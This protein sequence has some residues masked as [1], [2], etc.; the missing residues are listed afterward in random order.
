MSPVA[1]VVISDLEFGGAQRQVVELANNMPQERFDVH[2]VALHD[3][4]PLADQL[5][6]RDRRC[7][8]VQRRSKY[9]FTVVPR[10]AALMR[11]LR[12]EIVHGYLFDAEIASRLAGRLIGIPVIGSERNTG[13]TMKRSN[14]LAYR[15]TRW[16]HNF[17]IANSN[18]GADFNSK[19]LGQSRSTYRVVHNGVDAERFCPGDGSKIRAEWG[20]KPGELVVGM[21]A[22]FKPQKNHPFLLRAAKRVLARQPNTRF[23]LVGDELF[24]GM[25]GSVEFK[26][27][28]VQLVDDLGLR[29]H[30]AFAGNRSDVEAC[31][32][33][34][35]LTVLPSRFEG[36]PN[37]AL[38]SMASGVPVVATNVSD[39]AY[40]VPDGQAG[41]V[42]P[43]DDE[44]ALANRIGR[45]LSDST[46]RRQMGDAA[47]AWILA[48]FTG[49]RLAEKTAAVYDE[50]IAQRNRVAV[51][52][53][54]G[55]A[56]PQLKTTRSEAR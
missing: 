26:R 32:R 52:D 30:C 20:I 55:V 14:L 42:V 40:V 38:E 56:M 36:T 10:L 34:C 48:E 28:V 29:A 4:V 31:Y 41:F 53:V 51:G 15:A 54:P 9:D 44:D 47:R 33:A 39:N 45:L 1:L 13:Y 17:T 27:S 22:S 25:S 7:H 50:A 3:Y 24:K 37:V 8:I 43:L 46:L 18:A 35:D 23:V 5:H 2:V 49:R 11:R 21:F 12:A 19:I 6:E 16:C